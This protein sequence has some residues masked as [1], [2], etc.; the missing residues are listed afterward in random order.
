MGIGDTRQ[1]EPRQ[2]GVAGLGRG[3]RHGADTASLLFHAYPVHHGVAHHRV[4]EP[5]PAHVLLRRTTSASAATPTPASVSSPLSSAPNQTPVGLRP[6][7]IWTRTP[8]AAI[9]P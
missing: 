4:L 5:V 2:A 7:T 9:N 1:G 3:D 6:N 8:P